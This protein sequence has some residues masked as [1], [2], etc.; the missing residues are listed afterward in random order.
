MMRDINRI[1]PF[2]EKLE[3]IW[4]KHP[5]L[6]L[7]QLISCVVNNGQDLFY[8]EDNKLLKL[9]ECFDNKDKHVQNH[10]ST[11]FSVF[12]AVNG[13]HEFAYL[14]YKLIVEEVATA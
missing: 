13:L 8:I 12:E 9:L 3:E 2:L 11:I 4:S 14:Q 5:D 7:G 10:N 1:H 6:R